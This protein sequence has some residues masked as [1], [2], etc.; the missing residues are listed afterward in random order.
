MKAYMLKKLIINST[1]SE[2]RVA[3]IEGQRLAELYVERQSKRG[4]VGNI[5][6]AKV[7]RVLPGM[8]SAFVNIGADRS[9]FLYGGDVVDP[10]YLATLKNQSQQDPRESNN[11]TPIEKVLRE[12]QEIIVQVAK[13]P[14]G[15]KG[16]RVTMVVTI[17]GRYLVLMPEF[18]SVGISRRIEDEAVR[19]RLLA[20]VEQVRPKDKGVIIRTAAMEAQT[21]HL[22]KD[23][24]YLLKVWE[25]V[26]EKRVKSAAPALLY[27]EPDLVLKTTRDLYTED[28]AEIIVDDQQVY[29][30]L[31]HFMQDSIPGADQKLGLY[32]GKDLI[33]DHYG[34]EIEIANALS[35]KVWL[36]SG[37]YLVIDQTEA[38]TSFDVNTGKFVGSLNAQDTILK[39]NVEAIDEIV[40][41]LRIRNLGGIIVI[42]FIDME[43][44][45][46]QQKV[47]ERLLEALKADKSRTNVLA[48]NELGLVQMTRKRT[49]ESLERVL[50]SEC[51]HCNG[52]GRTL[53]CES[54]VYD[55]M[56][57]IERFYLRT[58]MK[59]IRIRIRDDVQEMLL[60]E[61]K[62][63]YNSLVEK[64][65]LELS[66]LATSMKSTMLHEPPY[67]VLGHS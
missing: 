26:Q 55:M 18:N 54:L 8:Q 24:D 9:A 43:S 39:T 10:D 2:T 58:G 30:Q 40:H 33:F 56:R 50:T 66:F 53:S 23:L 34:L 27:Q 16:P 35:R 3:L 31:Q 4:M 32:A 15:T 41:Q 21:E 67:E 57:D 1:V 14:L 20:E 36:P 64:Y 12:G 65:G 44:F 49:R 22:Q 28:V 38:L 51:A 5:Y 25:S 13:E 47:N 61:E 62:T 6:K 63:L 45:A 42:D 59:D 52:W 17:P 19:Q 29:E 7:S 11:R 48:I 46:D 37:G 60:N